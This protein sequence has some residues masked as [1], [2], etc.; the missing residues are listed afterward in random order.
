MIEIKNKNNCC[1]CFACSS[2]C[3]KQCI[4]MVEDEE[5]FI[6]PEVNKDICVDCHLCEKVC[7]IINVEDDTPRTQRA[8]LLQHKDAQI[9]KESTSGGAFTA[10]ATWVIKHGGVVF[11]AAYDKDFQ[12][13]HQ[14]VEKVEDLRIF[15]NSKYVQSNVGN[16]YSAA[17]DYLKGNRIVCFSGTPCQL[18]GLMR[19][20][21][22]TYDNL[23]T[24]DV[25]CHAITS[26]K[27][28]RSYVEM[29]KNELN[30]T[31]E[32]IVFRDKK[33]YGYQYS[34]M[35]I[36]SGGKQVYHEGVDNDVYL[37]SFFTNMNV[38]PSCYD[39][40]FKKR[41]HLTDFTLWDC[42]MVYKFDK[43][44]DNDKGVTRILA[45]TDK[46]SRILD[47]IR[48]QAVIVELNA[49]E[50]VAGV[51]EMKSSVRLNER[52]YA[53]FKDIEDKKDG[54]RVWNKY[55]PTTIRTKFEKIMRLFFVKTGLY[56]R[57]KKF[58]KKH[59]KDI[60]RV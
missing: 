46:A 41:Y 56:T 10:I 1:G 50:A 17:L 24:V 4:Q 48:D 7:P 25:M 26:P 32:N 23:I 60:K 55:Y 28:F 39:C 18:E 2:V 59:V 29:K 8:F 40:K 6:Y 45:N 31:P 12:V 53:L 13:T 15:R 22:K 38:R 57:L 33:P 3:P 42:F 16:A 21:R 37:R 9:L 58:I 35:S 47:E 52:R 20:I 34:S 27:L 54:K 11:G 36:Y 30:V 14:Y 51:K 5:G 19:F 49:D 43:S 44:L